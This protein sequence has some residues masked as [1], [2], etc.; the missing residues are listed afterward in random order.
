[1]NTTLSRILLALYAVVLFAQTE[2]TLS[3]YVHFA[4]ACLAIFLASLLNVKSE[5]KETNKVNL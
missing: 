3:K 4:I 5:P 2:V 1:M